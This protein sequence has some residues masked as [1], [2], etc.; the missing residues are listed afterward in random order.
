ME[1]KEQLETIKKA[2]FK[3]GLVNDHCEVLYKAIEA[4]GNNCYNQALDDAANRAEICLHKDGDR[5][6]S[7]KIHEPNHRTSIYVDKQSILNLK[8]Q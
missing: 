3:S 8:K 1:L 2:V 6:Y 7:V 4:Y 5:P